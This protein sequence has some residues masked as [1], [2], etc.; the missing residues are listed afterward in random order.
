[1]K[2]SGRNSSGTGRLVSAAAVD[3]DRHHYGRRHT[4]SRSCRRF[5][6]RSGSGEQWC[7]KSSSSTSEM[8]IRRNPQ[9]PGTPGSADPLETGSLKTN[10]REPNV[11]QKARL[12]SGRSRSTLAAVRC[13]KVLRSSRTALTFERS[14]SSRTSR[15]PCHGSTRASPTIG[16]LA[17][18]IEAMRMH[19]RSAI[20]LITGDIN[21]QNKATFAGVPFLE[22]PS[23]AA[24]YNR[25]AS[26]ACFS[27]H[28]TR[29]SCQHS[30]TPSCSCLRLIPSGSSPRTSTSMMSEAKSATA[31]DGCSRD[32]T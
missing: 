13:R 10:H 4:S 6:R 1:M 24:A 21:L 16:P 2:S 19:P 7:E 8:G 31:S 3:S 5:D 25:L 23:D 17:S 26:D 30:G 14:P 12:S 28:L 15:Q 20:A 9:V 29:C 18:T 22:P 32:L 11:R 27:R